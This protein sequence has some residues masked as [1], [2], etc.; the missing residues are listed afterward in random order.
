MNASYHGL[1]LSVN[2]RFSRSF[3]LKGF[4]TYSKS[5]EGAQLQN[6][7]TVGGFEDSNNLSLEK[8]RT[9][10]DRKHN[11]VMSGIWRL[12]YLKGSSP[13]LRAVVNGWQLSGILSLRSG[14]P[15][16]PPAAWTATSTATTTTALT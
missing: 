9:D 6:N 8:G 3:L 14:A 16:R 10:Y 15:L 12:E 2:K 4:Y 1:Q 5:L 7:T 11:I 13:V